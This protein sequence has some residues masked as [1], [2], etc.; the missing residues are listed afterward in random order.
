MGQAAGAGSLDAV[1][2]TALRGVQEALNVERASLLVF[3][4]GGTMR[5]VAWSG[6]SDEYRAAVDGHSPWSADETA[7]TPV[8]VPDIDEDASLASYV[9][10]FRRESIR[11]LAFVPVQFGTRLLGKFMLYFREPHAFSDTEIATTQQIAD[12]VAFAL[13]HHRI[14]VALESRLVAE[15]D[16]R[17]RAETEAALRE[18]N[19]RRLEL[20]LAAGRMGAWDWEIET[21]RVSWS[22]ELELIHGLVPGAFEG[23][24][25][26]FRRDVHPADADRLAAH[27]TTALEA[28]DSAYE[29][30]YRI[31]R[32]DGTVRWLGAT[33][34]VIV[35]STGRPTRMVGI[36]CDI[37]EHKRAEDA[38]AFLADAS[39]V[40][41]TTLAPETIVT[42]LAN[43]VVPRLADWCIVQVTDL[44]GRLWPVEIVHWNSE[45]R[46]LIEEFLRRWP[47]PPGVH[48]SAAFV[49]S[50]GQPM[51]IPR[52]TE[53]MLR[54]RADQDVEQL[55]LLRELRLHSAITVPLQARG[56]TVGALTLLSAES[57]QTY[58]EVD[59]RFVEDFASRAALAID[60]AQLYDA[61]QSA[62][63]ARDE[64]VAVVSHDL[65]EPLQTISVAEAVLRREPQCAENID[66]LDCIAVAS[67]EMRRLVHD[68]LDISLIEAGRLAIDREQVDLHDLLK[69]VQT[70]LQPQVE[71]ANVRLETRLDIDLPTITIDRH[72]ILQVLVNLIGN[73]LKFGAAD[74]RVVLGVQQENRSIRISVEDSGVG[75]SADQLDHVFDRFWRGGRHS[76]GAGLGLAVAKGIVEAHGGQIGVTSRPGTGSRF[77]FTLP[78]QSEPRHAAA[79]SDQPYAVSVAPHRMLT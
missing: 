11:A 51:L 67:L 22:A 14:A 15:R 53:D 48:G 70:L 31:V 49:S 10:V 19:E 12:H 37:T 40:L 71:A 25:D 75:I 79:S 34:R 16:L 65:R 13:E 38:R 76:G 1:Y 55:R 43:L 27:I 59:L 68:L 4:A 39:H 41:A 3:D 9:S 32:P 57:E 17:Q 6:L 26:A 63:K 66:M 54:E 28:P 58:D 30:E 73:A 18:S 61:A 69:E 20:A 45:R 7:A 77:F 60:N 72:R 42:N 2:Q 23:T 21:G 29:I 50:T 36:C 46:A 5:F 24:L 64:M 62:I 44:A 33:G 56:R 74:G 35:D 47:S 8:I 52:I 78:L